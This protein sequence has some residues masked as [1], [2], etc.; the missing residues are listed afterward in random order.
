MPDFEPQ[1]FCTV[2]T[3]GSSEP[4]GSAL[5]GFSMKVAVQGVKL[6]LE[7]SPGL[8]PL[9]C[10]TIEAHACLPALT[11]GAACLIRP[12]FQ[13]SLAKVP[14]LTGSLS[15]FSSFGVTVI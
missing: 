11:F 3:P 12:A 1:Q 8:G 5:A 15:Y 10:D 13:S 14:I 9:R 4:N 6:G 7:S 2:R